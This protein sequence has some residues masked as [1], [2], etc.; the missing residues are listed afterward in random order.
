MLRAAE[1]RAMYGVPLLHDG[2][3]VGVAHIGSTRAD[4][5]S[6]EEKKVFAAAAE[7]AALAVAKQQQVSQLSEILQTAPAYVAIVNVDSLEYVFVNPP[8]QE[9]IGVPLLGTPFG[10]HGL[11]AEAREAVERA[12]TLGE[13]AL[14]EE[15]PIEGVDGARYLRLNVQPLRDAS[16]CIDRFLLFATDVTVQVNARRQLEAAGAERVHLL[17]RERAAREAAELANAAKDEFLATISHELR[18][19]LTAI[20]GWSSLARSR[21][22]ADVDR[23]LAVIERN[24]RAQ[25]R[26]VEDVLDFSRMTMGKMRL[27][28]Q[29]LDLGEVVGGALDSVRPAADARRISIDI[30]VPSSCTIFGDPG[31]LQQVVWNLLANAVKYTG[32]GGRVGVRAELGEGFT[33]LTVSDTGQGIDPN[34]LPYVFE[35]FR[36]ANGS[37]TRRH[38]GLGLGLAIVRQIVDAHGGSIQAYSAGAGH[39]STFTIKLPVDGI[40]PSERPSE[41]HSGSVPPSM[42]GLPLDGLKVLV[43]DDD[44]D[45]RELIVQVLSAHGAQVSMLNSGERAL[46]ELERFRP[47]VLVSDI[48]MP[49]LDGYEL[50][51][52]VRALEPERGGRT[53]ALAV[54]AHAG[55]EVV[56]RVLESGFQRYASK[57][58]DIVGLVVHVSELARLWRPTASAAPL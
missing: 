8:L 52:L 45:G 53:P 2:Q 1:P 7:R 56:E 37:T 5:F 31:R 55:K 54:T 39:G 26:I 6:Q 35:A 12:R 23:A 32:S 9:L 46:L 57:P 25:A 48:A 16:D 49:L 3:L 42:P 43:I 29:W 18:T 34:F 28:P 50:I 41:P 19:P 15:L 4:K 51:R 13:P 21:P 40:E 44:D 11:A 38:G 30:G 47:D 17:E 33:N 27:S 22:K 14:V 36:Q 10:E 58:L 20:L 24:A